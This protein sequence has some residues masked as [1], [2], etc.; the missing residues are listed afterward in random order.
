MY[1]KSSTIQEPNVRFAR[2][3]GLSL[4]PHLSLIHIKY[5]NEGNNLNGCC[6]ICLSDLLSGHAAAQAWDEQCRSILHG[7]TKNRV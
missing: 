4:A 1:Q 3:F 6:E 5:V 7:G 2:V